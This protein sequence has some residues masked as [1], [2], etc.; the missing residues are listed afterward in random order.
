M[1]T[2][3]GN[4]NG[5]TQ[6]APTSRLGL[7]KAGTLNH[8]L[9]YVFYGSE[10]VGKSTLAAHAPK[11]IW[12]DCEDGT[13]HLNISRY[14]FRD[15]P[16][17]HVPLAFSE[18]QAAVRDLTIN[19]HAHQTLV[20]DTADRL[21]ALLWAHILERDS[22]KVTPF[23]KGGKTLHSIESYGFAKGYVIA[24]E[25]WRAFCRA[26][27]ELRNRRGMSIVWLGHAQIRTFKDPAGEDYD[28]YHLRIHDQAAGF[29]KEWADVVGFVRFEEFGSKLFEDDTRAK[30]SSTGRRLIMLERTAAY[31]AKTR[32]PLP[33]EVELAA[34]D[35]WAP[36]AAAVAAG[37]AA[38]PEQLLSLIQKECERIG[39]AETTSKVEEAC[40]QTSDTATLSRYLNTLR[41]RQPV[42]PKEEVSHV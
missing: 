30:G 21:Q 38:T 40:R 16:G 22:G 39:D 19:E 8:G 31:D 3:N 42:A 2:S 7:V 14:P 36:L 13:G 24:L 35:P 5:K 32:I 12:L 33:P 34:G 9:R 6:A 20:I 27:D 18:I 41:R 10:G 26:L 23:N 4:G 17:G 25:E 28:R 37:R 1:A 29:L 15:G 11:P